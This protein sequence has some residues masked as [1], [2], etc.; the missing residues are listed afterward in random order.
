MTSCVA[1]SH[2]SFFVDDSNKIRWSL[3]PNYWGWRFSYGAHPRVTGL[4][5]WSW[6]S[7]PRG[8]WWGWPFTP[9]RRGPA[10]TPLV[11]GSRITDIFNY[12]EDILVVFCRELKAPVTSMRRL[13]RIGG[14]R[15]C[16]GERAGARTRRCCANHQSEVPV[17]V[18]YVTAH[19]WPAKGG[20]L[21]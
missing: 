13:R 17:P 4:A 18:W 19:H 10:A 12:A 15:V 14:A 2:T 5:H 1:L 16:T 8:Y 7:P 3:N 6:T 20:A 11:T 9:S 21:M